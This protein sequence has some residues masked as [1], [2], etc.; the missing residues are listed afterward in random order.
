MGTEVQYPKSNSRYVLN[1]HRPFINGKQKRKVVEIAEM[2][3]TGTR[4]KSRGNLTDGA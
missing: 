3:T 4:R 1:A 2:M